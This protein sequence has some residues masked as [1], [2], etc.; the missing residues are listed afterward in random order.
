[1]SESNK[2]TKYFLDETKESNR[3]LQ[4][5]VESGLKPVFTIE[6]DHRAMH[7]ADYGKHLI[8]GT[9]KNYGRR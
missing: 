8:F 4:V 3:L 7:K 1:M 9:I 5:E 6:Y 2:I